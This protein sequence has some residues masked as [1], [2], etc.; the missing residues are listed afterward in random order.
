[1]TNDSITLA[2]VAGELFELGP[3]EVFTGSLI[4]ESLV[5]RDALKLAQFL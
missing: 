3:V 2:N 5:E 4:H 1:M